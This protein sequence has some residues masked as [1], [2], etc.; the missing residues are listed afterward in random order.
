MGDSLVTRERLE[1][2]IKNTRDQCFQIRMKVSGE[3]LFVLQTLCSHIT[4]QECVYLRKA[5][6]WEYVQGIRYS[7]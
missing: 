1:V 4:F 6:S 3:V 2:M 5:D 7:L